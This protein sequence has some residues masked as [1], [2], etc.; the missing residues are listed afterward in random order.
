MLN[1]LSQTSRSLTVADNRFQEWQFSTMIS[2][3]SSKSQSLNIPVPRLIVYRF[4]HI[5]P[6]SE[7]PPSFSWP[8]FSF[9]GVSDYVSDY[10]V[11]LSDSKGIVWRDTVHS[12]KTVDSTK[13]ENVTYF[14]ETFLEPGKDYIFTVE[15][16]RQ[17][18]CVDSC[19]KKEANIADDVKKGIKKIQDTGL[20]RQFVTSIITQLDGLL[21]AKE[22]ILDIIQG[23]VRQGSNSEIICFLA[24]FLG[25]VPGFKLLTKASSSDD[26]LDALGDFASQLAAANITLGKYLLLSGIQKSLAKSLMTKGIDLA[27][28][29]QNLEGAFQLT[30]VRASSSMSDCPQCREWLK[31]ICRRDEC[32]NCIDCEGVG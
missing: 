9:S 2:K 12:T 6:V 14:N 21:I 3:P 13:E 31:A 11:Q 20:P 16:D 28:F 17:Y 18:S 5:T 29:T 10:I 23:A 19:D 25:Q 26:T 7:N 24:D 32:E 1:E 27:L 30:Q 4:V 22:E 15:I 8:P